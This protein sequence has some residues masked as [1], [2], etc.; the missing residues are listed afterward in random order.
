[1]QSS[2]MSMNTDKDMFNGKAG[3]GWEVLEDCTDAYS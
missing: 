1:M 2:L 3:W